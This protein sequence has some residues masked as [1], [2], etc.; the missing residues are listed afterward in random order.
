MKTFVTIFFLGFVCASLVGCSELREIKYPNG[1]VMDRYHVRQNAK[2]NFVRVG[3][4]TRWY[5]NG[6]KASE[7]HYVS[8]DG[9]DTT[10]GSTG[11]PFGGR[12]GKWTDWFESGQVEK[13][14]TFKNGKLQGADCDWY[15]N[16]V[17]K[18]TRI[19]VNDSLEGVFTEWFDG[20]EKESEGYYKNNKAE[21]VISHWFRNGKKSTEAT[22]H[23]GKNEGVVINWDSLGNKISQITYSNDTLNGP[24]ECLSDD[25]V[26]TVKCVFENGTPKHYKQ[27]KNGYKTP[28]G[29]L[30]QYTLVDTSEVEKSK[31]WYLTAE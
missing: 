20:G 12:E 8:C 26:T 3:M 13:E 11:I 24:Y 22:F 31:S 17:K 25:G 6:Q 27:W 19:F 10:V 29:T 1:Q 14:R 2:K 4:F 15:K 18:C 5:E 16:G 21:G 7:G 30:V 23:E 9:T 28:T